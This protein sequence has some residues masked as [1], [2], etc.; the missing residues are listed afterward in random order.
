MYILGGVIA[1]ISAMIAIKNEAVNLHIGSLSNQ[2]KSLNKALADR[3]EELTTIK[4][5]LKEQQKEYLRIHGIEVQ[6]TAHYLRL[7]DLSTRINSELERFNKKAE[8]EAPVSELMSICDILKRNIGKYG[9]EIH[10]FEKE[11]ASSSADPF[12]VEKSDRDSID[13]LDLHKSSI[14]NFEFSIEWFQT[15]LGIQQLAVGIFLGKSVIFSS[16]VSIVF[17]FYGDI[18]INKYDI[19]KKYPKLEKIISLRRKYQK[20]Y[21]NYNCLLILIVILNE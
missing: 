18:L 6:H 20:Y 4:Q 17:I 3:K 5:E 10:T 2:V 12:N 1:N 15:L 8:S 21:F 9:E 11:V 16:L 13:G 19:T 14:F 7:E